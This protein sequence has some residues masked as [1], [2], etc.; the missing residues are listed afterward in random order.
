MR[1]KLI[2]H[3]LS[4]IIIA[5][6]FAV[7]GFI[8]TPSSQAPKASEGF[9]SL[10]EYI[11]P[12]DPLHKLILKESL[13]L[14][15]PNQSAKNDSIV[16]II[17]GGSENIFMI[18]NDLSLSSA[19][20]TQII[21]M[22]LKFITIYILVLILTYYGAQSLAILKFIKMRQN[23]SSYLLL[24]WDYL[25][26]SNK[27]SIKTIFS[28]LTK[29]LIKGF[30]FFI[31]FSPAYVIAYSIKTRFDTDSIF[32]MI[33]L[34]IVS[35]GLLISYSQKFYT[36]LVSES[37]KGYVNTARVKN[38]HNRYEASRFDGISYRQI[39]QPRKSFDKHVF[40]HI[41]KNAR[42]QFISS[43]KEQASF[44]ISGL[45]II[46]M[47][48]NI[49]GHLCYELLQN[50][51]YKNFQIVLL[52]VFLIFLLLK[53]TEIYSDYLQNHYSNKYENIN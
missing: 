15:Y 42:F 27:K 11:A 37:R 43:I 14:F 40:Q 1:R 6:I 20:I 16:H 53:L 8:I 3:I 47:A 31:L 49:Q 50:I 38:L 25:H 4:I 2:E 30:G 28:L 7:I 21:L 46:E 17:S 44:L 34:G 18:G 45:V 29:A 9:D 52:I 41:F 32:F 12:A 36:F 13:D 35:N 5:I 39:F 10:S 23:R 48:L 51:L 24:L 22:Y 19:K 33:L 26:S